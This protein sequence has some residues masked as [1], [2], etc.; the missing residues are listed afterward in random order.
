MNQ[1]PSIPCTHPSH[2]V[3]LMGAQPSRA[4]VALVTEETVQSLP[5]APPTPLVIEGGVFR[6]TRNQPYHTREERVTPWNDDSSDTTVE[7]SCNEQ[8]YVGTV[9]HG[10]PG[11]DRCHNPS[12]CCDSCRFNSTFLTWPIDDDVEF[13]CCKNRRRCVT[14]AAEYAAVIDRIWIDSAGR[15]QAEKRSNALS[16]LVGFM[17]SECSWYEPPGPGIELQVPLCVKIAVQFQFPGL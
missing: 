7:L 10:P 4:I 5:Y 1:V 8:P 3:S 13:V 14:E 16:L 15:S 6:S 2:G 11:A 12:S 9:Y 17:Q